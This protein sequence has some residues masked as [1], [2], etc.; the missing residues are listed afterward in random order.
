MPR[1][2]TWLR[3]SVRWQ[4]LA[5]LCLISLLA[6]VFRENVSVAGLA[7]RSELGLTDVELGWV[8]SSALWGYALFQIPGGLFGQVAGPRFA[9]AAIVVAWGA[10][11]MLCGVLPGTLLTSATAIF[12]GLIALRFLMGAVQAPLFPIVGGTIAAWFPP[13]RW[14]F[15]NALSSAGLNLGWA[16]TGPLVAWLMVTLGWRESFYLTAPLGF[17]AAALWWWFARDDPAEHPRVDPAELVLIRSERPA[18]MGVLPKGTLLRLLRNRDVLLISA[19]YLCMNVTFY[20]FFSWF[21]IYLVDVRGFTILQGGFLAALPPIVGAF[22]AAAGGEVCDRLCARIGPRWGCRLPG[23]GGLTAVAVLLFLG[24]AAPNPYLAVALL[25]LCFA[26]N[27]FTEGAYWQGTT[28][29]GGRYATAACGVLNTG[30]NLGGVLATPMIP[31]IKEEFGWI[32]ALASG[33]VFAVAGALLWLLVRA[34]RPMASF[35]PDLHPG[36]SREL[37]ARERAV[38]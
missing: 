7:I 21:F 6:Y 28:F 9:L 31:L 34:D 3:K 33:S 2:T 36:S 23:M 10:I 20:I 29:V 22:G 1:P 5:L 4:V 18:Q 25:S 17:A 12:F 8:L 32:A 38:P 14:A 13:S 37:P 16:L 26:G 15:P 19:S 24:A 27:Q 11:T 30:G 35:A